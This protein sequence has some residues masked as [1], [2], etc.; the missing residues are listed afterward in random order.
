MRTRTA[1]AASPAA[2]PPAAARGASVLAALCALCA[3]AVGCSAGGAGYARF[4]ATAT[5]GALLRAEEV[6][7]VD[8]LAAHADLLAPPPLLL[9]A[10][11]SGVQLVAQVGAPALPG[12]GAVAC[13]AAATPGVGGDA[14]PRAG[15]APGTH[16]VVLAALLRG[17]VPR[18]RP[19]ADVVAVVDV[20]GS[21]SAEDKIGY[22]RAALA[23]LVA[24]LHDDDRLAIVAFSSSAQ[25]V[26]PLVR[27]GEARR[28]LTARAHALVAGGDTDL[29]GGLSLGLAQLEHRAS[30]AGLGRVVL[31]TDGRPT[32][33]RTEPEDF[34]AL[35]ARA[36][37][38]GVAIATVGLGRDL[39]DALLVRLSRASGGPYEFLDGP[40]ELELV[41]ACTARRLV[42]RAAR[43]VVVHVTLPDGWALARAHHEGA[44][45]S[46]R[47]VEAPVGELG[48]GEG[49]VVLLELDAPACGPHAGPARLDVAAIV[50]ASDAERLAR[51]D[52]VVE[53]SRTASLPYDPAP[54]GPVR[55]ALTLASIAE[56]L[57]TAD[58]ARRS[59]DALG[60]RLRIDEAMREVERAAWALR[61]EPALAAALAEP[62]A[63][64]GRTRAALGAGGGPGG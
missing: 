5:D 60:A 46:G 20:S 1:R 57:R 34:E 29:Y 25:L 3:L 45:A 30:A 28:A 2:P 32:V 49:A 39:D 17:A 22:A 18:A 14:D 54:G 23:R 36:R 44:R 59:G 58:L 33:G 61:R 56:S 64:L 27:V 21:M 15:P 4:R 19:P 9:D 52:A 26:A 41:M 50:R 37:V 10:G 63:L 40:E 55:L 13:E 47:V 6:R 31:L 53:V 11:E 51:L 35:V 8:L 7:S 12:A 43:D 16:R 62:H 42:A 48:A 38:R 24:T